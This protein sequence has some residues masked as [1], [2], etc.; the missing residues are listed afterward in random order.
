MPGADARQAPPTTPPPSLPRGNNF[1]ESSRTYAEPAVPMAS[2]VAHPPTSSPIR[3]NRQIKPAFRKGRHLVTISGQI[4]PQRCVKCGAEAEQHLPRTMSFNP[5]WLWAVGMFGPV[6]WAIARSMT[7]KKLDVSV[8]LCNSHVRRHEKLATAMQLFM[9]ICIALMV[10]ALYIGGY[11]YL[12]AAV[13]SFFIASGCG[14]AS[15]TLE[16]HFIEDHFAYL[17][18][19]GK[20]YLDSLPPFVESMTMSQALS[21]S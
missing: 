20:K 18:G 10:A 21:T 15:I 2:A 7:V 1:A 5:K 6:P 14:R 19:A 12:I 17:R 8:P 9:G 16:P 3:P 11:Q 13:L 4:P